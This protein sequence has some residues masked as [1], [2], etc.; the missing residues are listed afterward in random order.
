MA[1]GEALKFREK[2]HEQAR[3]NSRHQYYVATHITG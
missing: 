1:L 3:H 2:A